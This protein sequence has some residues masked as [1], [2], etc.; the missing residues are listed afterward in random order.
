M[1][2]EASNRLRA[3]E[4]RQDSMTDKEGELLFEKFGL[5]P[6]TRIKTNIKDVTLAVTSG[7]S[8]GVKTISVFVL[9]KDTPVGIVTLKESW[10][11][12]FTPTSYFKPEFRS[13]GY[14][15]AV[16]KWV[17]DSTIGLVSDKL[18]S[19]Y[20]RNLW[21]ALAKEYTVLLVSPKED[22]ILFEGQAAFDH[23][24]TLYSELVLLGKN[25]TLEQFRRDLS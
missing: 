13:K 9:N 5:K 16:Y 15:K 2:I 10:F 7:Q 25:C 19:P 6:T 17:L 20:S 12:M 3:V 1:K 8:F 11:K 14:A 21:K 4:L 18:Q 23:A 22:K 24:D